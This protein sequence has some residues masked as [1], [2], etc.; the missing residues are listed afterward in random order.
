MTLIP[1]DFHTYLEYETYNNTKI[2]LFKNGAI[3][4]ITFVPTTIRNEIMLIVL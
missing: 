4:E 2:G 1:R 3:L